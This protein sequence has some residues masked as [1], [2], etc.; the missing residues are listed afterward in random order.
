MGKKGVVRDAAVHREVIE[1]VFGFAG[2]GR[3]LVL[4]LTYSPVKGP[5]GNIEY[6]VYL[7]K[8]G[9]RRTEQSQ[10]YK[11]P[12]EPVSRWIAD[13]VLAAH[14]AWIRI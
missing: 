3:I 12:G 7:K 13:V 11:A 2:E 10:E 5:E 4:H 1:K 6:L 8:A 14:D 9:S